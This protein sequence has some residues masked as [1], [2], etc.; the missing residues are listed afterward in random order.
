MSCLYLIASRKKWDDGAFVEL[1]SILKTFTQE[2]WW[3][4]NLKEIVI[5]MKG[6]VKIAEDK[7]S[8]NWFEKRNSKKLNAGIYCTFQVSKI[9]GDG[10]IQIEIIDNFFQKGK[11]VD[12]ENL[13]RLLGINYFNAQKPRYLDCALYENVKNFGI[14][15]N[16][17]LITDF[18]IN[19]QSVNESAINDLY[20]PEGVEAPDRASRYTTTF[21]RDDKVRQFVI[22]RTKGMCELCGKL[23]FLRPSGQYY[24]ETHHIIYLSKNGPDTP[25]NVIGLCPDHHREAHFGADAEALESKMNDIMKAK[26]QKS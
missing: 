9:L 8:N 14:E 6:L 13:I 2:E 24:I 25:Q 12:K 26:S 20:V 23:G 22:S 11:I 21:K 10:W 16:S 1:D 17:D 15:I 18:G 4:G 5:G 3:V 19:I 7:N